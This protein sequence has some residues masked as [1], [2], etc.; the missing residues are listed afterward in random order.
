M[1]TKCTYTSVC[2]KI[3]TTL[4]GRKRPTVV[5]RFGLTTEG[6]I[7][8]YTECGLKTRETFT[9]VEMLQKPMANITY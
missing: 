3:T 4:S 8:L 5:W 7:S 1:Y 2:L 9:D 6:C